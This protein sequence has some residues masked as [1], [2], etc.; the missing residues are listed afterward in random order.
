MPTFIKKLYYQTTLGVG[1]A[2][3]KLRQV[4]KTSARRYTNHKEWITSTVSHSTQRK[5]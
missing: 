4:V 3:N 1:M 5:H 2:E